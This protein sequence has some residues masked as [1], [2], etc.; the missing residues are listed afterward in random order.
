MPTFEFEFEVFMSWNEAAKLICR[1]TT[2][3]LSS[4]LSLDGWM[5]MASG[6]SEDPEIE[7]VS[8]GT[9]MENFAYG[10]RNHC[11]CGA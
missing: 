6:E 1:V 4:R 7:W 8:T 9:S 11:V 2:P 3:L 10:T 5:T